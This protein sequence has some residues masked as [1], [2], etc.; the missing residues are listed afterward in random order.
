MVATWLVLA[1]VGEVSYL[2]VSG[3]LIC[4]SFINGIL[5]WSA[6]KTVA[7]ILLEASPNL[8]VELY[9]GADREEDINVDKQESTYRDDVGSAS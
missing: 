8:I 7:I 2:T 1:A 5:R 9:A 4:L 6:K 3:T